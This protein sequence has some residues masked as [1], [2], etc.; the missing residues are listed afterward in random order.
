MGGAPPNIVDDR[1]SVRPLWDFPKTRYGVPDGCPLTTAEQQAIETSLG[2]PFCQRTPSDRPLWPRV[3]RLAAAY[4][5]ATFAVMVFHAQLGRVFS[6]LFFVA[7]LMFP[8]T[9]TATYLRRMFAA[10]SAMLLVVLLSVTDPSDL[11]ALAIGSVM[12]V[13]SCVLS[14][15]PDW[16]LA[17]LSRRWLT[18]TPAAQE[19]RALFL[20][21][22]LC[23]SCAHPL[24]VSGKDADAWLECNH[25]RA[26]WRPLWYDGVVTVP[27]RSELEDMRH[28]EACRECN[29]SLG[30]LKPDAEGILRCPECGLH[31]RAFV[32]MP[33]V[34]MPTECWGCRRSLRGLP[35]FNGD[36]VRC[37][38][39][40]LWRSGVSE[41][42]LRLPSEPSA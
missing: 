13:A 30:G 21:Q 41:E 2:L 5:I 10:I 33:G 6:V 7:F 36:R 28:D 27:S 14:L 34:L 25:C 22:Y 26:A 35:L 32:R 38:D 3:I 20:N 31:A 4:G 15:A 23:P 1:G 16:V 40:G 9:D 17:T 12:I 8:A 18:K 19:V 29:Y 24:R 42:D 39:C 37:P 11:R